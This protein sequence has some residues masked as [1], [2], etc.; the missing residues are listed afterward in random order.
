MS[1]IW[2]GLAATV[3][4]HNVGVFGITVSFRRG[5]AAPVQVKGIFEADY[6]PVDIGKSEIAAPQ[7]MIFFRLVD[8]PVSPEEGDEVTVNGTVYRVEVTHPDGQ[9]GVELM[10]RRK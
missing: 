10:L 7:P 2:P 9:G 3:D 6:I 1:D 5:V 4:F 8:L